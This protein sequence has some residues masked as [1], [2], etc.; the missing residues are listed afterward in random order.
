M[1]RGKIYSEKGREIVDS[2]LKDF[3]LGTFGY[4]DILRNIAAH[5]HEAI[6]GSGYLKGLKGDEVL[7]EASISA[8]ADVFD[9]LT[10]YRSYK[11]SWRM[12]KLLLCYKQ[13]PNSK[14]DCDCANA[15][16]NHV[17]KVLEIQQRSRDNDLIYK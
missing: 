10:S 7:I 4:V 1:S 11:A 5:H 8:M 13:M 9:A 12:K 6:D 3:S 2:I 15:L 16:I 17:D 14:L